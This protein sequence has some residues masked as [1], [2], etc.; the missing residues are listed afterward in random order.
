MEEGR[1]NWSYCPLISHWY[2]V[3]GDRGETDYCLSIL[4][5]GI[6]QSLQQWQIYD[7]NNQKYSSNLWTQGTLPWFT[8]QVVIFWENVLSVYLC[9]PLQVKCPVGTFFNV[10]LREC[11]PCPQGSFQPQEGQVS[12]LVCPANTSTKTGN[13][14]SDED[15]KGLGNTLILSTLSMSMLFSV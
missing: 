8:V 14:K 3:L 7:V 9:S 13:A 15:C 10:I 2:V 5:G 6:S 4:D 1:L 11:Q 12:C